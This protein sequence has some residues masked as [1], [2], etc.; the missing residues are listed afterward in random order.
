MQ[1]LVTFGYAFSGYALFGGKVARYNNI[2]EA[3]ISL[4]RLLM[5]DF[6]Y[7]NLFLADS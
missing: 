4:I 3:F 6:N 5:S 2:L 1:I 7:R